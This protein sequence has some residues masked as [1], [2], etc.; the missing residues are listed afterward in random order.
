MVGLLEQVQ[1]W[2]QLALL[3]ALFGINYFSVPSIYLLFSTEIAFPVDQASAAGYLMAISQTVGFIGG[4]I[5][6]SVLNG[7]KSTSKTLFFVTIGALFISFI[8]SLSIQED[9][10]KT[11][12]EES[13]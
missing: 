9:L 3:S 1:V 12:F 2:W 7:S 10:R 8:L 4:I 6:A 5:Y 13:K 11:R